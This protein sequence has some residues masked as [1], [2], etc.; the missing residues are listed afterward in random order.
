[1]NNTTERSTILLVILGIDAPVG[2]SQAIN[3]ALLQSIFE[4]FG[5]LQRIIIFTKDVIVKAFVEY[6]VP[7]EA[8][9]AK[10]FIHNSSFNNFG[11]TRVFFSALQ[12]LEFS[13]R[14]VE[15]KD[16][17][18]TRTAAATQSSK[19]NPHK[20]KV[21]ASENMSNQKAVTAIFKRSKKRSPE[22][23]LT[24]KNDFN[25]VEVLEDETQSKNHTDA[26][27]LSTQL[28][29][30]RNSK[31]EQVLSRSEERAYTPLTTMDSLTHVPVAGEVLRPSQFSLQQPSMHF[32]PSGAIDVDAAI[33]EPL[34]TTLPVDLPDL[35]ADVDAGVPVPHAPQSATTSTAKVV[36][37]S[38]LDDFFFS[39]GDIFNLFSC[40]G[41][42]V[43]VLLMKNLKKALVEYKRPESAEV[44]V[45]YMN[46]KAFGRSKLKVVL[47][48]Y[49]K[50]DLKRNNKSENSQNFNEVLIVSNK[51]N[52]F[53]NS[54]QNVI[55]PTD[56]LLVLVEKASD[57]GLSDVML[58]VQLFGKPLKSK[59]LEESVVVGEE[60][61]IALHQ[62]MFK[63]PNVVAAM[64]VLA[65]AHNSD[66]KG[67]FLSVTFA[68]TMA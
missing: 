34:D 56:T 11:V 6:C 32:G 29:S 47:S 18:P 55:A 10:A 65:Q 61:E 7:E 67:H 39:A 12:K 41:N 33:E 22:K 42:V 66:V 44:A 2:A 50:I 68:P 20:A 38:N 49:K 57:L 51:M 25:N 9:D 28:T 58:A 36:L 64:K 21:L 3:V 37:L 27:A 16:L 60:G 43:R 46:N 40:F 53:K 14:F 23:I 35:D 17:N 26:D 48:K 63:F 24:V 8:A 5:S 4:H 13:S 59:T 31:L 45:N 52:R 15:C 19:V 30:V 54:S 1:M 62:V